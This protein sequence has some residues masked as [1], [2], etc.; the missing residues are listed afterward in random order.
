MIDDG[1]IRELIEGQ[2]RIEALVSAL[3]EGQPK[4]WYTTQEFAS[5]IGKAEATVREHCRHGRLRAERRRSGRGAYPAWTLP[6]A[7]LLRYQR[8]GLLPDARLVAVS[9]TRP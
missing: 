5:A 2:R 1:V 4:E 9:R 3:I 7:E 8:E 6:H